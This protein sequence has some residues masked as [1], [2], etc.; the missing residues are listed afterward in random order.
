MMYLSIIFFSLSY[1]Y[2]MPV[3][4]Y[5]DETVVITYYPRDEY[6]NTENVKKVY[7]TASAVELTTDSDNSE[8]VIVRI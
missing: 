3:T 6:K 8:K 1:K 7:I 2:R 5:I 4:V